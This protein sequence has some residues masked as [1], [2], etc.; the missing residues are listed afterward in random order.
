MPMSFWEKQ[1]Y[2]FQ[3]ELPSAKSQEMTK[4]FNTHI[5]S[6]TQLVVCIYTL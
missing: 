3:S 5:T 1:V 2:I 6:L 4:I